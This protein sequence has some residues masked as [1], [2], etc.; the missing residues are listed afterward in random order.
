[1]LTLVHLPVT[2]AVG[3]RRRCCYPESLMRNPVG[4]PAKGCFAG[5]LHTA[6][7]PSLTWPVDISLYSW[8]LPFLSEKKEK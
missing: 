6:P 8:K 1:M 2:F 7:L 4:T 3:S 5:S